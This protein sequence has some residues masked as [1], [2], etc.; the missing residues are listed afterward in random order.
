[1]VSEL[2]RLERELSELDDGHESDGGKRLGAAPL[3]VAGLAVLA[4]GGLVF[5]A[6]N[7]GIREGTE[8][9]APIVTPEGPAKVKPED[10][11][12]LAVPH[13]D[14]TVYS[15]VQGGDDVRSEKVET[16]LPPPEEPIAPP[17]VEPAVERSAPPAGDSETILAQK[18]K[19]PT[20]QP[21]PLPE[22]GLT[23]PEGPVVLS[24]ETAEQVAAAQAG[25]AS[26]GDETAKPEAEPAAPK[27][28]EAPAEAPAKTETAKVAEAP[29]AAEEEPKPVQLAAAPAALPN[30][31]ANIASAWRV[32]VGAVR[33][34]AA[35]VK[36]WERLQGRNKDL[37]GALNLQVQSVEVKDKGMF[38]RI[39]GGPLNDKAA[40]DGLCA[41]LKAKKVACLSIKPGA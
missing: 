40:A 2:D 28:V 36:E 4:L 11:G 22:G 18:P 16:L 17:Q 9:A 26:G 13:Q 35:A 1:M 6:Y 20:I 30:A 7:E 23:A 3:A 19:V 37:L 24:Q 38:Y 33:S 34:E 15:V 25:T 5:Y 14:K 10:P 21:P 29:K 41:K 39:R 32:Q 31:T 12:G 27:A 8:V